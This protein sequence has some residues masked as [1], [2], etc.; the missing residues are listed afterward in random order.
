MVTGPMRSGTTWVGTLL[1]FSGIWHIHEPFNPNRA[2]FHV[3]YMYQRVNCVNNHINSYVTGLLNGNFRSMSK[4]V[5][6]SHPLMPGNFMPFPIRRV[7]IKDPNACLL[8]RY[9]TKQFDL[10]TLV[11][12]RHPAAWVYSIHRLKWGSISHLK[13]FLQ[14]KQLIE[15]YLQPFESDIVKA[16]DAGE[17][18]CA[19]ALLH[20][21]LSYV[22]WN[23]C[24]ESDSIRAIMFEA[25]CRE[26]VNE[27]RALYN[28]LELPYTDKIKQKHI[29]MS[30]GAGGE[31]RIKHMHEV[32]RKSINEID[33]WR[34]KLTSEE[35]IEIRAVFEK[36]E[37]PLYSADD[38]W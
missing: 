26:P 24:K 27:F 33:K 8:S 18:I 28:W 35:T 14:D 36:F 2:R 15:D 6:T 30:S 37:L 3:D 16:I 23:F 38:E 21:C 13:R 10:K 22:L 19:G 5:D 17:S 25:L 31:D 11:M 9:L 20:G 7:L 12:F 34:K 32:K 1:A 4:T 29:E